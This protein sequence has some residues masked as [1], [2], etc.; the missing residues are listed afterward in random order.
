MSLPVRDL[1]PAFHGLK[2]A[3]LTDFHY[4]AHPPQEYVEDAIARTRAE[5][6]DLIALTGDFIDRGPG[7]VKEARL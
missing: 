3:H 2:I 5:N 4:G 6:P 1:P 7:H